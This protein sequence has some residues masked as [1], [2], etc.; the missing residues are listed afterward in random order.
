MLFLASFVTCSGSA[1][2]GMKMIRAVVLFKQL[3]R[4]LQRSVHPRLYNPVQI[5]TQPIENKVV[6]AVLAFAFVYVTCIALLTLV[7]AAS[8]LDAI[9][10]FSA[11]LAC[12]NNT[13]P[14]LGEVGPA[15]T[16][17]VLNDFQTWLCSFAMLL[18]RLEIFTLLVV[19]SP[20]FWR[21]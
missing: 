3:F 11:V 20:A 16:F 4:E 17:A 14:G 19:L 2:G 5:A 9:S 1:G 6:F 18:G 12:I 8:G 10:A 15:K 13:G 21:R 7:L